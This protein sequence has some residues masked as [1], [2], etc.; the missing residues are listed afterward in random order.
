MFRRNLEPFVC[1]CGRRGVRYHK[2]QRFCSEACRQAAYRAKQR[3][4]SSRDA[5]R[6]HRRRR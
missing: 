6:I 3:E 2:N 5:H 1:P 4:R